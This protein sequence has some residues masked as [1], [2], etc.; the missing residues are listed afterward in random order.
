MTEVSQSEKFDV[1]IVGAGPA[2]LTAGMYAGRQGLS[3]AL[4]AGSI[5]GQMLWAHRVENFIGWEP[6]SGTDLLEHF[7]DHVS[8]FDVTC[9]EGNLVNAIVPAEDGFDV[10][11]REGLT[12]HASSVIIATGKA[13]NRLSIPGEQELVGRGVSYCATCDA[14]FFSGKDVAVIGPG[15]A[16]ADAALQLSLLGA[17]HVT[18]VNSRP[19]AAPE[20][21]LDKIAADP[22]IDLLTGVKPS[23]IE[24]EEHVER[25]VMESGGREQALEVSGVFIE[26]GSISADEFA[27]GLVEVNDKG[28]I[29][30]DKS[31]ATSTLGVYAAGDI[32]D[33][34]GK[35]IITAAGQGARAAMAA[36]RDLKRR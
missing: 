11:T 29:V 9:Y 14:A 24:G 15:E 32:T 2:G 7:R 26:I 31:G 18:L 35:Q 16:A 25:L 21:V 10:F 30:I 6:I 12:L 33:E 23:R 17:S 22:R 8:R 13:P 1:V 20:A 5:G 34:F 3:T 36:A 27:L 19:I 4:V 28:E